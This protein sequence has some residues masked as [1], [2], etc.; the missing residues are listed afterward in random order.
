MRIA[1][2]PAR[3]PGRKSCLSDRRGTGGGG[4]VLPE[5][6]EGPVEMLD[7]VDA[8]LNIV[9]TAD[10][11]Q[12]H[13]E[14]FWHQT[15][16]CWLFRREEGAIRLLFQLRHPHR[17]AN[18]DRLDVTAAGHIVH[19]EEPRDGVRELEEELGLRVDPDEL[20][21]LGVWAEEMDLNQGWIDREYRHVHLYE[22]RHPLSTFHLQPEEVSGLFEADLEEVRHLLTGEQ[23]TVGL[24]GWVLRE[25]G[26]R[27][28]ET[29]RVT[30]Q[31]FVPHS[32]GYYRMVFDALR[33][34]E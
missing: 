26:S 20:I 10:R 31:D 2:N 5:D 18:P 23:K 12:V 6:P 32:P 22:C 4:Y 8:D 25:D 15:F 13:Q 14:G 7:I 9:G 33:R 1:P 24:S 29:R 27:Q 30:C 28:E 3:P 19:G 16:H 21:S 34:Y 11:E 17:I